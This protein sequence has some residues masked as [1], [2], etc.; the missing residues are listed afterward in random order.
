MRQ[1]LGETR[2]EKDRLHRQVIDFQEQVD[3]LSKENRD[4][5][6]EVAELNETLHKLLDFLLITHLV[7]YLSLLG[8]ALT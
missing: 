8:R 1:E 3:R 6:N 4:L 2:Q 5:N 7:T